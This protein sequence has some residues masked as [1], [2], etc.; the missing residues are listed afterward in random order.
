V[1][2]VHSK[3]GDAKNKL[4]SPQAFASNAYDY[5]AKSIARVYTNYEKILKQNNAARILMTC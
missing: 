3:I 4:N 1:S 2:L 5:H